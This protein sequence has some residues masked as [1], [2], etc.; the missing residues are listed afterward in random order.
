V[1]RQAL[2]TLAATRPAISRLDRSRGASDLAAD[3]RDSWAGVETAI[4]ALLG[5]SPLSGQPLITEA[6]KRQM[7]TFDQANALAEYHA[8]NER[9]GGVGYHPSEADINAARRGF[10]LFEGSLSMANSDER[11]LPPRGEA[12]STKG[13]R[14]SPLGTPRPVPLPPERQP[15]WFVVAGIVVIAALAVGAWWMLLR[16]RATPDSAFDRGVAEFQAG[17]RELAAAEF[18]R[19]VRENPKNGMAHVYL[20]RLSREAG[21]AAAAREHATLAVQAE[22]Q[23][24]AALREMGSIL[25]AARDF[26]MARRF[27]VRALEADPDDRASQ[28]WLGCSLLMLGRSDEGARWQERAGPGTWTACKPTPSP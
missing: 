10:E 12:M 11:D 25:L 3:L 27:Y 26:E 13:L 9:A 19:V 18:E 2:A 7:L 23:N 24:G 21:N 28:G 16:G 20:S 5:G 22:P 4:R 15:W 17:R 1:Q 14:L 6:R 8:A